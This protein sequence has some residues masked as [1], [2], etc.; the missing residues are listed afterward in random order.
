[1]NSD[2]ELA[3]LVGLGDRLYTFFNWRNEEVCSAKERRKVFI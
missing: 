1:M 3:G 2:D